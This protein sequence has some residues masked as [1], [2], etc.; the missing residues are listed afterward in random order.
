MNQLAKTVIKVDKGHE[1]L[2]I[3]EGGRYSKGKTGKNP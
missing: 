2:V 1:E 3:L